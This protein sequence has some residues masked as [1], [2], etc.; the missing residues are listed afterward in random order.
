M[1]K[2]VFE[3]LTRGARDT[4]NG[5]PRKLVLMDTKNETRRNMKETNLA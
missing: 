2:L 4:T 5:I 3:Y 1:K